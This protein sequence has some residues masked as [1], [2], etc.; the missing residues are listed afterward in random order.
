MTLKLKLLRILA[1]AME[2]FGKENTH[3]FVLIMEEI[4]IEALRHERRLLTS[5]QSK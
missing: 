4:E 5:A 1:F 2:E 3:L